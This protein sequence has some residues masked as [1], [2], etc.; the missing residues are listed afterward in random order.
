MKYAAV[1]TAGLRQG[2][3]IASRTHEYSR[4][5]VQRRGGGG[6]RARDD[7]RCA[8]PVSTRLLGGHSFPH[9]V[10]MSKAQAREPLLGPDGLAVQHS[11]L[12]PPEGETEEASL[13]RE[14]RIVELVRC[15]PCR[16]RVAGLAAPSCYRAPCARVGLPVILQCCSAGCV[17]GAGLA[18][19][20][21]AALPRFVPFL[22]LPS[23]LWRRDGACACRHAVSCEKLRCQAYFRRG[24]SRACALRA[25]HTQTLPGGP[26][27]M[28]SAL[29]CGFPS[30][31]SPLHC[32]RRRV[33]FLCFSALVCSW[34]L[35]CGSPCFPR[36]DRVEPFASP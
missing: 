13:V 21:V 10:P 11:D 17:C 18:R 4:R 16:V 15:G 6:A 7:A 33:A 26:V 3:R 36:C 34:R 23:D 35:R 29:L 8:P 30:P 28:P 31:S 27:P 5:G 14:R 12:F 20:R 32:A 1:T 2:D 22:R 19:A 9:E 24:G 25:M